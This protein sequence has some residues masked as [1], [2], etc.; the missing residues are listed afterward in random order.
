[1]SY[2]FEI[3]P[4]GLSGRWRQ[5]H[6]GRPGEWKFPA[7]YLDVVPA[8]QGFLLWKVKADSNHYFRPPKA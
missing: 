5:V 2:A 6:S 4:S 1:V 7:T 8:G 3:L